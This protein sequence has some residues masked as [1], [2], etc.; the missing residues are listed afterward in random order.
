MDL[1][2]FRNVHGFATNRNATGPIEANA[3]PAKAARKDPFA[4]VVN[5]DNICISANYVQRIALHRDAPL[6]FV[7][8]RPASQGKLAQKRSSLIVVH[9]NKA[10][11]LSIFGA[12][13]KDQ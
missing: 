4:P 8:L 12:A 13:I 6:L 3:T 9:V 7:L 1:M 10:N 11:S 5:I 2:A